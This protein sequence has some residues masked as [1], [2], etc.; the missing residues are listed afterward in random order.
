MSRF[1]D[2]IT[3]ARTNRRAFR[4]AHVHHVAW[5]IVSFVLLASILG[6]WA[7][8]RAL[9]SEVNSL[10]SNLAIAS[11]PAAPT[12]ETR[13]S[14][15]P[16]TTT[17]LA[18]NNREVLI[19]TPTGFRSDRYLPV[20]VVFPGKGGVARQAQTAYK[21]DSLPAI[22]VYPQATAG[23]DGF[24]AW[25]G[26]PYSSGADDVAFTAA[27]L[28][29]VETQL[30]VDRTKVYAM[31]MSNGGGFTALLSCKMSER[32]AAYAV[33]AGAMYPASD[34]CKPSR[35]TAMLAVHG[36]NDPI[37]PYRGSLNRKLPSIDEW[38]QR[39]AA[40]NGCKKPTSSRVDFALYETTWQDCKDGATVKS[41][42]VKGGGHGWGGVSNEY[43]WQ[44]LSRFSL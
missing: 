14:W 25:Q 7:S 37:V 29:T 13:G 9:Q 5:G 11:R 30:C 43:I 35:P 34:N 21:L 20:V 16:N 19:H 17:A 41:I 28:D 32:F 22:M 36:D 40:L 15:K 24:Y 26:A 3:R 12:C 4:K 8:N 33:V 42:R 23:T 1:D 10:E 6:M 44:F 38:T 18:V 39:R 27:V 2:R 31:G